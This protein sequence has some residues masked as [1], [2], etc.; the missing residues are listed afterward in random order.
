M[1]AI[2]I[3]L[4]EYGVLAI[5][6]LMLTNGIISAP[7]SEA[8]LSLAGIYAAQSPNS[9]STVIFAAIAGNITGALV[10]YYIGYFLGDEWAPKFGDSMKK[11]RSW[12]IR[13]ASAIFPSRNVLQYLHIKINK[14]GAIWIGIFRCLPVVRS[15]VS[16]PAGMAQMA[17]Y[18]FTIISLLGITVWC[19]GWVYLGYILRESWVIYGT[20]IGVILTVALLIIIYILHR[21]VKND[22]E[23]W[24]AFNAL[25]NNT[26]N[27]DS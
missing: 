26:I 27:T 21:I 14:N 9:L 1:D 13:K 22:Y 7:A 5:F 20:A 23:K 19:S 6:F 3:F 11:S 8:T 18:K 24:C 4:N 12:V 2:A 16:L 17:V 10:L 25:A 15:I